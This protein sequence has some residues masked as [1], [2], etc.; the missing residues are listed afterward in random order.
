MGCDIHVYI[1]VK[2]GQWVFYSTDIFNY[3]Y[4]G[5]FGFLANQRNYS[6]SDYLQENRGLPEDVSIEVKQESDDLGINGH[7]HGWLLLE[8]LLNFDYNKTFYD[9]RGC[10]NCVCDGC[11]RNKAKL[12]T[13]TEFLG[14]HFFDELEELK[15]LGDPKHVRIVFW[16][17][18]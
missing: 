15:G 7:S 13:Y 5:L 11:S 6:Q 4:Y 18:N 16:F 10:C 9:M 14:K 17:D 1:E 2:E 3:R 12:I 8:E